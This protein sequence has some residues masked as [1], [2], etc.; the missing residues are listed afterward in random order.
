MGW[1]ERDISFIPDDEMDAFYETANAFMAP[2]NDM[3]AETDADEVAAAFFFACARYNAFAMQAQ[4]KDP[5]A[6]SPDFI[7]FL[8]QRFEVELL[9]HMAEELRRAPS[10]AGAPGDPRRVMALL[11]ALSERSDAKHDAFMDKADRFI[12]VANAQIQNVRVARVSAA[13]MHAC[14]R[15]TVFA[16][17]CAG[18]APGHADRAVATEFRDLYH[19]MLQH[20]LGDQLIEPNA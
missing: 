5:S 15:F 12:N 17:Q 11:Q 1:D 16:M 10:D 20:H 7:D 19:R 14:A 2:A 6:V 9:E 13:F 8:C 18:L 3:V 4:S